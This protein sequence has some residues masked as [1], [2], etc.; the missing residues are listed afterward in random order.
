MSIR[1]F[2]IAAGTFQPLAGVQAGKV[3]IPFLSL[4]FFFFL[5]CSHKDMLTGNN[6]LC[7]RAQWISSHLACLSLQTKMQEFEVWKDSKLV[8]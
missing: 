1:S 7:L 3:S 8:Y 2:S 6:Y 4:F 5:I